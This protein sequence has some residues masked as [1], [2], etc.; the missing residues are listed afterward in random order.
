MYT[1]TK[2]NKDF[3][4]LKL[5]CGLCTYENKY[6]NKIRFC[7][8]GGAGGGH[9]GGEPCPVLNVLWLR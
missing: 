2:Q 4:E 5:V 1:Y 7:L 9:F 8:R 3:Y 6:F